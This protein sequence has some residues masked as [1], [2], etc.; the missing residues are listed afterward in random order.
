M[1][2]RSMRVAVDHGADVVAGKRVADG[3]G[4]DVHDATALAGDRRLTALAKR[5]R[6]LDSLA[7]RSREEVALPGGVA[8]GLAQSLVVDVSGAERV[9]VQEQAAVVRRPIRAEVHHDL[10]LPVERRPDPFGERLAEKEVAVAVHE[11]QGR[12]TA[13]HRPQGVDDRLEL[14]GDDVVAQPRFEE[15]AD[16]PERPGVLRRIEKAQ[17]QRDDLGTGGVEVQ[18]G[19]DEIDGQSASTVTDSM[20]TGSVGTSWCGPFEPVFTAAIALTASMP[21]TTRPNTQ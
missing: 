18:V 16:D 15:I 8:H 4:R 12:A 13:R 19:D 3:L 17:R 14:R 6:R 1:I 21:S 20:T 5:R 11:V 2:V 10:V 9:A 7:R